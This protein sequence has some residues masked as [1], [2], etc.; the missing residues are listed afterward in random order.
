MVLRFGSRE[1]GR[2]LT[3]KGEY[4][5]YKLGEWGLGI[6]LSWGPFDKGVNGGRLEI[7]GWISV[8]LMGSINASALGAW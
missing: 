4:W 6:G 7:D 3:L 1:R 8:D 2:A 5:G